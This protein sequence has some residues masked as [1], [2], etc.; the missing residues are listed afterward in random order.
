[1]AQGVKKYLVSHK[2][3]K[4]LLT[5]RTPAG[6]DDAAKEKAFFL[7]QIV[8]GEA[9]SPVISKAEACQYLG[10]MLGG[11]NI[12]PLVDCLDDAEL[13]PI[14]TRAPVLHSLVFVLP[15]SLVWWAWPLGVMAI[16]TLKWTPP[17][18]AIGA[19]LQ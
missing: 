12:Q 14:A 13:A 6:V 15:A 3:L 7:D 10:T 19:S 18:Y 5:T 17:N 16:C 4:E 11:Y 2:R 9:T 1:M 8:K